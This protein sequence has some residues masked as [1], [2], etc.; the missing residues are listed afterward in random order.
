MGLQ[1]KDLLV[2]GLFSILKSGKE[3]NFFPEALLMTTLPK[4]LKYALF[5]NFNHNIN[6]KKIFDLRVR[7]PLKGQRLS[8][9]FL[10]V[11]AKSGRDSAAIALFLKIE[12]TFGAKKRG[13]LPLPLGKIELKEHR[14][15]V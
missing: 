13:H 3:K 8:H 14:R 6:M 9:I 5:I 1:G 7:K 2:L 4:T 11:L 12:F 10:I 15:K